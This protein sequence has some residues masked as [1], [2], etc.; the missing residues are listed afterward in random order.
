MSTLAKEQLLRQRGQ[1]LH[2]ANGDKLGKIEEI[3]VDTDSGEPEWALVNTGLFGTKSSFV[4][5][6]EADE[7]GET[8]RVPYDKTQVKEAPRL[9]PDGEL[10]QDDESTLYAH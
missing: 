9:D 7:D 2:D 4:P 10:S 6:Q 8:L 3:Y 5:L 1:D